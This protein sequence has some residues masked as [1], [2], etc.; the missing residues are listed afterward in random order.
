MHNFKLIGDKITANG[1]DIR[2]GKFNVIGK[3]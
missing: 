1:E 3:A 2:R